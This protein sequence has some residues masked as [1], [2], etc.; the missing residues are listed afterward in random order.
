MTT[1]PRST[2]TGWVI[3]LRRNA[4]LKRVAIIED[5]TSLEV[6]AKYNDVG[7]YMLAMDS[8]SQHAAMATEPGVYGL[9]V[10][11][12]D[13]G[14]V[15]L[16]GPIT[17]I[18]N[19][20]DRDTY[21]TE[22][23]GVDDNVWLRRRVGHPTPTDTSLP[24]DGQSH[25][26][27]EG[28]C[29]TVLIEYVDYNLGPSAIPDRRV[30]NLVMA[31]DPQIGKNVKADMRWNSP[32]LESIWALSIAGLELKEEQEEE[33]EE[34]GEGEG[35]GETNP[36][37]QDVI[38]P[39]AEPLDLEVGF[40]I[41]QVG[42]ELQFQVYKPENRTGEV[43]FSEEFGNLLGYTYSIEAPEVNFVYVAGE[44]EGEERK[45]VEDLNEESVSTWGRIEVFN[46]QRNTSED[47]T[48]EQKAEEVLKDGGPKTTLTLEPIDTE[49]QR[50]GT[51]Y[52]LGDQVTVLTTPI[53]YNDDGAAAIQDVVREIK[54]KL[55][56]GDR[57][58]RFQ[59]T[60][61]STEAST[62]ASKLFKA[63]RR[64]RGRVN[65]LEAI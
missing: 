11:H 30:P 51:H 54:I 48:L 16:S 15:L 28:Q 20:R 17:K 7:T 23:T 50:Y 26:H 53:E 27:R 32:L 57:I 9:Y 46:D 64:L 14:H 13:T 24:Y 56:D 21:V 59:A 36:Q 35:E 10:V 43:R 18:E 12:E 39:D 1:Y 58:P 45:I 34:E 5:Y 42:D 55:G 19:K 63:F 31:P 60:V 65:N 3:Y 44:G 37:E 40:R 6:T 22:L 29:S 41:V 8:R 61:G 62:D 47:E 4:D 49:Y 33:E 38:S 25:D 52:F 2:G